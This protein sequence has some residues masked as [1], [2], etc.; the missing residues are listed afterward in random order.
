MDI[1]LELQ[2]NL[3]RGGHNANLGF[4]AVGEIAKLCGAAV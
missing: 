4:G 1:T 3:E 2:T